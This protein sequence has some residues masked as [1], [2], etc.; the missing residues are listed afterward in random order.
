MVW[1]REAAGLP[2]T[3]YVATGE[4]GGRHAGCDGTEIFLSP[5]TG[6][7]GD[8]VRFLMVAEVSEVMMAAQHRGW[9]CKASA[10]EG[11]SRI[12]ATE[13][14]PAQLTVY[15]SAGI[16]LDTSNR[17]DWVTNNESSDTDELATGCST[18]F[19]N[20]LHKQLGFS[21]SAIVG[22]AAPTLAEVYTALTG[23]TDAF[24]RFS[25]LLQERFPIGT[26]CD[27]TNDNPFPIAIGDV[28]PSAAVAA[29]GDQFVFWKGTDNNLWQA[30]KRGGGAWQGP[31]NLG[32]GPLGS[33]P[34]AGVDGN[35]ATYVYWKGTDNNL[36]RG[37]WNGA[38]W[39]G[40]D[41]VG[42]GPLSSTPSV[43][44][45]SNGDQFVFWKGTDNNL[46]QAIK[47][48]GGAWQGPNNLGMG[49]L[50]SE[51][52]AGVDGNGA[53]YVYWKG[54]DNNL[55]RGYWNGAGWAGPDRVG[56]GPLSSTP[57][58]AVGSNGDQ[59]VFWKGTDNNLWQAIKRGGGAWQG[60]NNLGMGPLGSE[61]GAGVD[62]NGATYVYWK[63]TD[64]NLWRGYWNGAR[65]A[66]PEDIGVGS[67]SRIGPA[68]CKHASDP[69]GRQ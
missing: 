50:G 8:F 24:A 26:P 45:G 29:G 58:V 49:P 38:G 46:W 60:P 36:W 33:E 39:A 12:L 17:P 28:T 32:M 14:Y 2:F 42:M 65:W 4:F 21:I 37:Y 43:A 25:A 13:R 47:R 3:I 57:S 52:G 35:G 40:P 31:N 6:T 64:N 23:R 27:L 54:T 15:A 41:R 61:P 22:A 19:L 51:P 10:G 44:V 69:P 18:L 63:G 11:L 30:I 55:W 66:G 56:M 62:G 7:G 20:Y 9:N 59:F 1:G 16:W 67:L 68:P 34:G 48:G 5:V 53:T